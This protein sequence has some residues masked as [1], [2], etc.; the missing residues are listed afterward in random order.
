M[1]PIIF[2]S[3]GLQK[4]VNFLLPVLSTVLGNSQFTNISCLYTNAFLLRLVIWYCGGKGVGRGQQILNDGLG[5]E[6]EECA[7]QCM[8]VYV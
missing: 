7:C 1:L 4:N 3:L 8:Y 2:L 5:Y 6:L